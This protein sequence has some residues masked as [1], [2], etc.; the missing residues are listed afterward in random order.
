MFGMS[1]GELGLSICFLFFFLPS[2]SQIS[3]SDKQV[4]HETL[5]G[6]GTWGCDI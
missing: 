6:R 3:E 5:P 2:S 1:S 4:K